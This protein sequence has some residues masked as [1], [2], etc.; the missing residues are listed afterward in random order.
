MRRP[1]RVARDYIAASNRNDQEAMVALF[2]EDAEWIPIHPITPRR[3][4][5]AIRERYLTQVRDLNAPIIDDI[6]VADNQRCVVEFTVAH[7]ERGRVA[8]V[9]IFDVDRVGKITRLAVYRR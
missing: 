6:Y 2:A 5:P 4:K 7:P 9:D 8:I 3:G 1:E